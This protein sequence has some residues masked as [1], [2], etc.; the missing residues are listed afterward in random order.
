MKRPEGR[1]SKYNPKFCDDVLKLGEAGKS[2]TQIATFLRISRQT[3]LNWE[4]A[5]PEFLDAMSM[6]SQFAQSWW[7][8]QGQ[9][10]I[11]DKSFN[12]HVYSFQMKN[13]FRADYTEKVEVKHDA[14][15]AFAN[16]W[17]RIG[18]GEHG[19]EA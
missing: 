3:L 8:D 12:G 9:I 19:A 6:A 4:E 18:G 15:T 13:R 16:I 2:R 17:Q 1:P 14:S 11:S 5:Y 7:E 10:G